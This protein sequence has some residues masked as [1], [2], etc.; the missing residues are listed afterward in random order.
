MLE[1]PDPASHYRLWPL[2][3]LALPLLFQGRSSLLWLSK[4]QTNQWSVLHADSPVRNL[5]FISK[6]A[7]L[8]V[9]LAQRKVSTAQE[10]QAL[11]SLPTQEAAK[12]CG[13][14]AWN[15]SGK[16]PRKQTECTELRKLCSVLCTE[17]QQHLEGRGEEGWRREEEGCLFHSHSRQA[18]QNDSKWEADTRFECRTHINKSRQTRTVQGWKT[19]ARENL[20]VRLITGRQTR[21]LP[22]G[23]PAIGK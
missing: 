16:E 19:K 15:S 22:K 4:T 21:W 17:K 5:V 23:T 20:S 3:L 11:R 9:C 8:N 1:L 14:C 2:S 6:R 10:H 13:R 12:E 18:K 7:D